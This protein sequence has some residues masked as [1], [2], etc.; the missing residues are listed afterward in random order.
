MD[1]ALH[2]ASSLELQTFTKN[3]NSWKIKPEN[4]QNE[5][6]LILATLIKKKQRA[7]KS[8]IILQKSAIQARTNQEEMQRHQA[9]N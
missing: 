9:L 2:P 8:R 7:H 3:Q 1:P 4:G 5:I 6:K